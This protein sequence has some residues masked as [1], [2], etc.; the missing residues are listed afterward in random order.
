MY[1]SQKPLRMDYLRTFIWTIDR[2]AY[3][4]GL[5][6]TLDSSASPCMA[7]QYELRLYQRE[8]Q[9]YFVSSFIIERSNSIGIVQQVA[10]ITATTTDTLEIFPYKVG[11]LDQLQGVPTSLCNY[12]RVPTS[13]CNYVLLLRG[14]SLG[15]PPVLSLG[16]ALLG[17]SSATL[18]F[19]QNVHT[20]FT[21]R[22]V[23]GF[24]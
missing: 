11:R 24:S 15:S 2:S 12:V 17:N 9:L 8:E 23:H 7:G 4:N 19:L 5:S 6:S 1:V 10:L 22:S 16:G 21:V 3:I 20:A 14:A 13:L 18:V